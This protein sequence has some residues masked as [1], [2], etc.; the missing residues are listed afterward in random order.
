LQD[1]NGVKCSHSGILAIGS[2]IFLRHTPKLGAYY[3]NADGGGWIKA[4]MKRLEGVTY[5]LDEFHLENT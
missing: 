5:V 4:G 1:Q 3:L 2:G